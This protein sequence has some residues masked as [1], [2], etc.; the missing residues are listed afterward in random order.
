MSLWSSRL[1]SWLIIKCWMAARYVGVKEEQLPHGWGEMD[2]SSGSRY[3]G[4]WAAGSR[5][6]CGV[7]VTRCVLA[8]T[9]NNV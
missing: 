4:Q 9:A 3:S 5:E 8:S 7:M 6:G 1:Y 2:Y